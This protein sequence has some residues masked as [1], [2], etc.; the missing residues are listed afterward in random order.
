MVDETGLDKP[1]VDETAVDKIAVDKP[2][3]HR[4]KFH[5]KNTSR[6]FLL[7]N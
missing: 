1:K 4:S 2:E 6:G 3:P 7:E 5:F